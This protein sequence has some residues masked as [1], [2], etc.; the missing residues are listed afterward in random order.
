MFT[1]RPRRAST[2]STS[3]RPGRRSSS[4]PGSSLPSITGVMLS[5]FQPGH[6][7]RE[8][9][10]STPTTQ[11]PFLHPLPVGPQEPSRT[12]TLRN[13]VSPDSLSSPTPATIPRPLLRPPTLTSRPSAYAIPTPPSSSSTSPSPATT[14]SP[15]Q[16]PAS[17]GCW[18]ERS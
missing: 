1:P 5:L 13:S 3:R 14:E 18:P 11:V 16:S 7:D 2:L 9:L 10:S 4:P 6:T 17:T 12:K 15:N 8:P